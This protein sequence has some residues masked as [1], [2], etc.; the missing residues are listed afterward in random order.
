MPA[1]FLNVTFSPSHTKER[2]YHLKVTQDLFLDLQLCLRAFPEAKWY[3]LSLKVRGGCG[4]VSLDELNTLNT[5]IKLQRV[6]D[7]FKRPNGG[8]I[9][10]T[11][12]LGKHK[13]TFKCTM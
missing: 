10:A 9:N 13:A 2:L 5:C 7:H 12:R 1:C 11:S 6:A 4:G 8:F 3:F